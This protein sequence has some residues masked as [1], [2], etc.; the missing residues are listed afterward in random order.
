VIAPL[1]VVAPIAIDSARGGS[2]ARA[3]GQPEAPL[4]LC[5]HGFPDDASPFNEICPRG[6]IPAM[7]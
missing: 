3:L 6:A 4:V 5:L 2:P 1:T 7:A